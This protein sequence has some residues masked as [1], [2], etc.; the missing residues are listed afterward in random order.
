MAK[1]K[2][3]LPFGE[4]CTNKEYRDQLIKMLKVDDKIVCSDTVNLQD[5]NPTILFGPREEGPQDE[6]V[7]P[8]YVTIKVHD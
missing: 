6:G 8:F 5:D 2:I 3:S 4:I 1:I 7:P